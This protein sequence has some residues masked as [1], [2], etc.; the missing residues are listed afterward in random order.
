VLHQRFTNLPRY[1]F[2]PV[3]LG[4]RKVPDSF[5]NWVEWSDVSALLDATSFGVTQ[6][7]A[8]R[9]GA[10]SEPLGAGRTETVGELI[11]HLDG[12]MVPTES[13]L[14][15]KFSLWG[16]VLKFARLSAEAYHE[17]NSQSIATAPEV[18]REALE[19]AEEAVR[20]LYE[21][22]E[23][24]YLVDIARAIRALSSIPINAN[25]FASSALNASQVPA[26]EQGAVVDHSAGYEKLREFIK[27]FEI[28]TGEGIYYPNEN[29]RFVIEQFVLELMNN[30]DSAEFIDVRYT[31]KKPAALQSQTAQ[32]GGDAH[33]YACA[34]HG[35][36]LDGRRDCSACNGSGEKGPQ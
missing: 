20:T 27:D 36:S 1:S 5:G 19:E 10:S 17:A 28:D 33:C 12:A 23:P 21:A 16:R 29:E 18:R 7:A 4:I 22:D 3:A 25:E 32:E 31:T 13:E 35:A 11:K 9:S 34:G 2:H 8:V 24:P 14:G 30:D 26:S 6:P 15:I